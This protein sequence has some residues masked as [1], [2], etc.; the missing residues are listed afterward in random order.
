MRDPRSTNPEFAPF[1][2]PMTMAKAKHHGLRALCGLLMDRHSACS[3]CPFCGDSDSHNR[4]TTLIVS[5]EWQMDIYSGNP[6]LALYFS[7]A[8]NE[9]E[10]K[11]DVEPLAYTAGLQFFEEA[12]HR[13]AVVPGMYHD[14][15]YPAIYG[16][17]RESA[18]MELR[19]RE[20]GA[21]GG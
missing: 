7:R 10:F 4:T 3:I 13:K 12:P 19:H 20:A 14:G 9:R 15:T 5:V 16:P 1:A 18:S 17:N 2:K 21:R 6:L 11:G 8:V